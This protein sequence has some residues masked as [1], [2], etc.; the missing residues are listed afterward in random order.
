MPFLISPLPKY[1]PLPALVTQLC[2]NITFSQKHPLTFQAQFLPFNLHSISFSVLQSFHFV[3]L[4]YIKFIHPFCSCWTF[5]LLLVLGYYKQCCNSHS[6]RCLLAY[7]CTPSCMY[8]FLVCIYSLYVYMCI[9]L[10]MELLFD[11]VCVCLIFL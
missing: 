10:G 7:M 2:L 4:P 5:G 6:H 8:I 3:Y 1:F 9:F 11:R